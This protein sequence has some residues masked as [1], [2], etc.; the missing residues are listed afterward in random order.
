MIGVQCRMRVW[1]TCPATSWNLV[2][3]S[4]STLKVLDASV[5]AK[6][7]LCNAAGWQ[8]IS[9]LGEV[10]Q[11]DRNFDCYCIVC[12]TVRTEASRT[13]C[14][15]NNFNCC[16]Q[17]DSH[18]YGAALA[19][20]QTRSCPSTGKSSMYLQAPAFLVGSKGFL[21]RSHLFSTRSYSMSSVQVIVN[22]LSSV[23][24]WLFPLRLPAIVARAS[25]GQ[26]LRRTR[27]GGP[28]LLE[29]AWTPRVLLPSG[30]PPAAVAP[31]DRCCP[32]ISHTFGSRGPACAG[33]PLLAV[34]GA[35]PRAS[36]RSTSRGQVQNPLAAQQPQVLNVAVRSTELPR[37]LGDPSFRLC[38]V[39]NLSPPTKHPDVITSSPPIHPPTPCLVALPIAHHRRRRPRRRP[40]C[41]RKPVPGLV[42]FP[43][44]EILA[45]S[46]VWYSPGSASLK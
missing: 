22:S 19:I 14:T 24:R 45:R 13:D 2:S 30:E 21:I 36:V 17:Y 37:C 44:I 29:K 34:R 20:E 11:T 3:C 42:S 46:C 33:S 39:I 4:V 38:S 10:E 9:V 43:V 25:D 8:P 1:G 28:E 18:W 12:T 26:R 23:N 15:S 32:M 35:G 7:R 5:V 27:T 31:T 40:T 16:H 41:S 6:S